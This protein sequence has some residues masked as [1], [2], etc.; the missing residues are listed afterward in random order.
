M[1]AALAAVLALALA[2]CVESRCDLGWDGVSVSGPPCTVSG[3]SYASLYLAGQ[4]PDGTWWTPF[5]LRMPDGRILAHDEIT[6]ATVAPYDLTARISG[7]PTE[8]DSSGA[9][10]LRVFFES[11]GRGLGDYEIRFKDGR[12]LCINAQSWVTPPDPRGPSVT[13]P[14]GG[15]PVPLPL[16]DRQL[17]RLFGPWRSH[18]DLRRILIVRVPWEGPMTLPEP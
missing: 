18:E 10:E 11:D 7:R 16:S 15:P 12:L 4:R 14:G 6:P 2:G 17:V 8:V 5:L 13:V 9:L 1:R 3:N